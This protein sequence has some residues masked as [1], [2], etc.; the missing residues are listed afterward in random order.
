MSPKPFVCP[1]CSLHCDDLSIGGDGALVDSKCNLADLQFQAAIKSPPIRIGSQVWESMDWESMDWESIRAELQLP[2]V[3]SVEFCGAS[4]SESKS[5][6]T[7]V[8]DQVIQIR[9][10][11]DDAS[12]ALD[13]TIARDGMMA[14]TLGDVVRHAEFIW[15]VGDIDT[16]TPR[17][18][19]RL[20]RG[21]A[22][23]ESSRLLSIDLLSQLHQFVGDLN[24][25]AD[26]ATTTN[27]STGESANL[28]QQI[29]ASRYTAIVIGRCPFESGC[30][31]AAS[32]LLTRWIQRW[33]DLAIPVGVSDSAP[34]SR[35]VLLRFAQHQNL[36]TVTR[37]RNNEVTSSVYSR[38]NVNSNS[39]RVGGCG[40]TNEAPVRLQ[41]GGPDAGLSS[42]HAYIPA[43]IPGLHHADTTIRGDG[44]VTLPL[45]ECGRS[46]H[47]SR[48]DVLRRV[49]DVV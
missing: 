1:F 16:L 38:P 35:I 40:T 28:F 11:D 37:W 26:P 21:K 42:A 15:V 12:I 43:A 3:P 5:L 39:I 25:A 9:Y 27:A 2:D 22:K 10:P 20:R 41:I 14:A 46:D 33:N 36:R 23:I 31:V 29:R 48:I 17:L 44:S 6:E 47:P 19:E 13:Q 45:L 18:D 30:E 8:S 32:E 49:L 24:A 4:I 34:I 7:L